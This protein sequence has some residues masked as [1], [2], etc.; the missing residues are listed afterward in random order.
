MSQIR[1]NDIRDSGGGNSST[2]AQIFSGRAKAWV[3]F[4]GSGTV[5][6]RGNYNVNSITDNGSGD[7]T[8]NFSSSLPNANYSCVGCCGNSSFG[9]MAFQ[10]AQKSVGGTAIV[11]PTT[12]AIRFST[13][14]ANVGAQD[15]QHVHLSVFD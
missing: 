4:N 9:G 2:P 13:A 3:N 11:N 6:M 1:V 10:V 12:S 5:A 15:V 7:Y 14:Q 8:A